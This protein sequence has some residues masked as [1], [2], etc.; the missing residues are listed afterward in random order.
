MTPEDAREEILVVDDEPDICTIAKEILLLAGYRVVTA[1]NGAEAL[2]LF[3]RQPRDLVLTD[4]KM[5]GMD[6]EDLLLKIKEIT[7]ATDVIVMTAHPTLESAIRVLKAGAYDY[8]L[9]PFRVTELQ[10]VVERCLEKQRLRKELDR[11][12]AELKKL[13]AALREAQENERQ[14]LA[15]EL[16]DGVAQILSGVSIQLDLL[17]NTLKEAPTAQ[18]RLKPIKSLVTTALDEIRGIVRTL[19]P[20]ALD[21]LGLEDALRELVANLSQNVP[22]DLS[23]HVDQGVAFLPAPVSIALYRIV[24]EALSNAIQHAHA[25]RVSICLER[26]GEALRLTVADDGCGIDIGGRVSPAQYGRG[27][28]LLSMR[29][30][31]EELGGTF[32]LRSAVGHGTTVLVALPLQSV[33]N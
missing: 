32:T 5:P 28:G 21:D 29:E 27:I 12:R 9:K 14:R 17:D 19:R 20:T 30:R 11:K 3:R 25:S 10:N 18:E 13:A 1:A 7:P 15:R 22:I 23:L 31:A 4:L 6:G 24:Q 16:H 2:T 26:N 8:V 33:A